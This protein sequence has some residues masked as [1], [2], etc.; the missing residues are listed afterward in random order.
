MCIYSFQRLH[1]RPFVST[2]KTPLNVSFFLVGLFIQ[3]Q[4]KIPNSWKKLKTTL[5]ETKYKSE[6]KVKENYIS[7]LI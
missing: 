5:H 2:E 4:S 1:G 6:N 7:D 3:I